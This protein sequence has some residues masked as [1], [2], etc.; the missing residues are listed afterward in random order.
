MLKQQLLSVSQVKYVKTWESNLHR[1]VNV[2]KAM[3]IILS[4]AHPLC[5]IS[6]IALLVWFLTKYMSVVSLVFHTIVT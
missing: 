1:R 4:T 6:K 3:R 5:R 2:Y